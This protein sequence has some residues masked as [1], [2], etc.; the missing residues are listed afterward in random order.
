[1]FR[2]HFVMRQSGDVSS[3]VPTP[4]CV[5][6]PDLP[7]LISPRISGQ[8]EPTVAAVHGGGTGRYHRITG[9]ETIGTS[10][11]PLGEL[12]ITRI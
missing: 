3:S 6:R 12:P 7:T 9:L 10:I 4:V 11:R 2:N 1:M 8:V 5:I